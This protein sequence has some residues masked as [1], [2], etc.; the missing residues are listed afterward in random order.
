MRDARLS[1]PA[2]T[3]GRYT[4][5]RVSPISTMSGDSCQRD[6]LRCPSHMMTSGELTFL[7][8]DCCAKAAVM[9]ERLDE[10]LVR[11][12]LP[13]SYQ[14]IDLATLPDADPRRGYPTPTLLRSGR[15]L[16]GMPEPQPPLPAPT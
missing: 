5:P 2:V 7:T 6:R 16:F 13:S 10:A 1:N 4:P 15:D 9:R 8:R 11:R 3:P 12:R 14:V